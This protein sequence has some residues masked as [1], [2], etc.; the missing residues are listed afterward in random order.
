MMAVHP[1]LMLLLLAANPIFVFSS[2]ISQPSTS[3]PPKSSTLTSPVQ[4]DFHL[5]DFS[6]KDGVNYIIVEEVDNN[7]LRLVNEEVVTELK[8]ELSVKM[9]LED[10]EKKEM[11]K[12]GEEKEKS[13]ERSK[14]LLEV[15]LISKGG[16][17]EWVGSHLGRCSLHISRS[18]N[19]DLRNMTSVTQYLLPGLHG[20]ALKW[21][22]SHFTNRRQMMSMAAKTFC[23]GENIFS[24]QIH[25]NRL[26]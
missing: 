16:A 26:Q 10:K 12:V 19:Q 25:R 24:G 2:K 5:I 9:S 15:D 22:D 3:I 21:E 13:S 14:H 8:D 20:Q 6:V 4:L 18:R 11:G 7:P 23:G 17:G 1:L